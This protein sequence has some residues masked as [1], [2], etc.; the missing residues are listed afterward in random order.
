MEA[1]IG[2]DEF[3]GRYPTRKEAA[4]ALYRCSNKEAFDDGQRIP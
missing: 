1:W 3:I 4:S 2:E